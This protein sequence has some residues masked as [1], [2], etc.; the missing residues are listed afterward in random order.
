MGYLHLF[1]EDYIAESGAAPY[2][3]I[4]SAKESIKQN[5]IS[6]LKTTM[7]GSAVVEKELENFYALN[8]KRDSFADVNAQENLK[9]V[10]SIMSDF[11]NAIAQ[12]KTLAQEGG[13]ISQLVSESNKITKSIDRILE[14]G[15]ST[16][17][18]ADSAYQEIKNFEMR[19]QWVAS[20]VKY[21]QYKGGKR[22][23]KLINEI[24]AIQ[25]NVSG[26][27]LELAWVY[28]FLV[29]GKPPLEQMINIGGHDLGGLAKVIIDP[30]MKAD[31]AK[32]EAALNSN[33]A[34]AKAD[35]I[36]NLTPGNVSATSQWV[37][38]QMKN[39]TSLNGVHVGSYS[40][41][42]VNI[43]NFYDE[44]FLVNIAGT[45]A[46]NH[47]RAKIPSSRRTH[48]ENLSSQGEVDK[49]WATIKNSTKILGA[50]DAIAG[51]LAA[52][53][54]NKVNYYVIRDKS[55][56][57]SIRVIAVSKIIEKIKKALTE[58]SENMY[59]INIG[60]AQGQVASRSSFWKINV[61]AFS[62]D[63]QDGS[64]RSSN[65]YGAV[66]QEI[67]ATKGGISLNFASLFG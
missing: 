35:V 56:G 7:E 25:S 2:A 47:Y 60:E 4:A 65:A 50:A 28:A 46:G 15:A 32:I 1:Y 27:M 62:P 12:L 66:L 40:L 13:E 29:A 34:Q 64:E 55:S 5:A 39:V 54:T 21:S 22:K 18:L 52:N 57:G 8:D 53:F 44:D 14:L 36:F 63:S 49:I 59:G 38:F 43:N 20:H 51:Q 31:L 58:G 10:N 45:L 33:S 16:G 3:I 37:G 17:G 41:G 30:K 6:R 26:Y 67:L 11:D 48:K 9:K 42:E 19:M 24:S 23:Q 61:E